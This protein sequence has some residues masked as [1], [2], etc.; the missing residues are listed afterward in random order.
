M[1]TRT[2]INQIYKERDKLLK[3]FEELQKKCPHK[4]EKIGFYSW[5]VGSMV[6]V[7]IC[8][9]CDKANEEA[10]RDLYKVPEM[11]TITSQLKG[12]GK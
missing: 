4:K 1:K 9:E 12:E 3:E 2:R 5:R 6:E 8:V 11:V 10:F 7:P